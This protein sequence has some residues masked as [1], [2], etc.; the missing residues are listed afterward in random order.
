MLPAVRADTHSAKL[1][2][3]VFVLQSFPH[4]ARPGKAHPLTIAADALFIE[5]AH[6]HFVQNQH[7]LC[8]DRSIAHHGL[9]FLFGAFVIPLAIA[10]IGGQRIPIHIDWTIRTLRTGH[11]DDHDMVAIYLLHEHI[12]RGQNIHAGLIRVVDDIPKLSDEPIRIRE[13]N[14]VQRLVRPFFHTQ[15]NDTAQRIGKSGVGLPE[16]S[17]QTTHGLLRLNAVILSILFKIAEVD[18]TA[19]PEFISHI[20]RRKAS[21]KPFAIWLSSV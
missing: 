10:A 11:M 17:G 21:A 12:L 6:V 16:A 4:M 9:V 5:H 1:Q 14:R 3:E 15:Q 2:Q 7:I 18:H 19:P 20:R 13:V 8:L